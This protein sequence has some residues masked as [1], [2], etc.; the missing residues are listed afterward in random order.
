MGLLFIAHNLYIVPT[1]E[2]ASHS[3]IEKDSLQL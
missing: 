3:S 2:M 1:E